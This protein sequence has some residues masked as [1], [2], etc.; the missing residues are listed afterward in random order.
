M[1]ILVDE[2]ILHIKVFVFS[3]LFILN[4]ICEISHLIDLSKLIACASPIPVF[5]NLLI[6]S[7]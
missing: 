5:L 2:L 4:I 7:F 6:S 3:R 1:L